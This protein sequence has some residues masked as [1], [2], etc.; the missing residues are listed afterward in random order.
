MDDVVIYVHGVH[1]DYNLD[2]DDHD[3]GGG[4]NDQDNVSSTCFIPK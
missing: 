4:G 1:V 2:F 3:D